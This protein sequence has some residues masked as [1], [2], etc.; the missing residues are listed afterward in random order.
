MCG[1]L[2]AGS[3]M[4]R[5]VLPSMTDDCLIWT[6]AAVSGMIVAVAAARSWQ[7]RLR[8]FQ[9]LMNALDASIANDR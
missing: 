6:L 7:R 4:L 9:R 5:S 1:L 2:V 3:L 8:P